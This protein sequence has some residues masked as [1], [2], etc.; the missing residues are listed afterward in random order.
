M[1]KGKPDKLA[2]IEAADQLAQTFR[3][4]K[5]SSLKD[6][7]I[8]LTCPPAG[9]RRLCLPCPV[10]ARTGRHTVLPEGHRDG[11]RSVQGWRRQIQSQDGDKS[12]KVLLLL[13]K[14][15]G[16]EVLRH[17]TCDYR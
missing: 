15:Q 2:A 10:R 5:K 14:H 6:F 13:T 16:I 4:F 17:L 7:V 1:Y 12:R 11:V 8:P 3:R 9:G